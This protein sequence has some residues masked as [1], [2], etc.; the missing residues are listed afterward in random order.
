MSLIYTENKRPIPGGNPRYSH[1]FKEEPHYKVIVYTEEKKLD[2]FRND[3]LY[4]SYSVAVGKP[5]TPTPK[6]NF[7]IINKDD[8]PIGPQYGVKWLGLSVP[9]IGIH[10]TNDPGSIGSASSEGCVRMYN[11]DILEL[12][13]MLPLGTP[14]TIV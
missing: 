10:G 5:S 14:V 9:H 4:K 11:R 2:L 1:A 7:R 12:Y 3:M 6:G 8:N 13:Y